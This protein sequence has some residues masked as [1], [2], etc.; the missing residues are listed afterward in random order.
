MINLPTHAE[1]S[2][3]RNAMSAASESEI[4]AAF[5]NVR[6]GIAFHVTLIEL[7]QPQPPTPLEIDNTT[8]H[9]ASTKS[10]LLKQ[11]KAMCMRF[12]WLQDRENQ[13]KFHAYWDKG[14]S[15]LADYFAKHHSAAHHKR[16]RPM[17]LS[18]F[19]LQL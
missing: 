13:G 3:L 9:R 15:N 1:A 12:Y 2:S 19:N 16:M 4:A 5:V 11:S 14:T 10:L 7:G 8:T 18:S 17:C 6:M